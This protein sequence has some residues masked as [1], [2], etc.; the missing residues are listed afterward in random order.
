MHYITGLA[1]FYQTSPTNLSLEEIRE[2]Q[3]YMINDRQYSPESVNA[4]VSASKFLYN[5]TLEIPWPACASPKWRLC[6]WAISIPNAGSSGYNRAKAKRTAMP[7]SRRSCWK[8]CAA[9]GAPS[10]RPASRTPARPRTGCFPVGYSW[11]TPA[12]PP[13]HCLLLICHASASSC[14][15]RLHPLSPLGSSASAYAGCL[16]PPSPSTAQPTPHPF[17]YRPFIHGPKQNP[18]K[19]RPLC[20]ALVH[21]AVYSVFAASPASRSPTAH[22]RETEQTFFNHQRCCQIDSAFAETY[23]STTR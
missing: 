22:R 2:Y 10:I 16:Q 17:P 12:R 3:L 15:A 1:R 19:H 5:L 18:I 14:S 7:C 21:R 23:D 9:G 11:P 4:F 20:R 6:A 13:A 8:C